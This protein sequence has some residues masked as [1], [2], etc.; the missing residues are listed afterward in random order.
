MAF[1]AS[2]IPVKPESSL[3]PTTDERKAIKVLL[4]DDDPAI[5]EELNDVIEI[6]GWTPITASSVDEAMEL[7]QSDQ[8]IRVVVTDVHFGSGPDCANGIQFVSRA[9]AKFPNRA[10]SYLVLSGDSDQFFAS[11]DESAF[12]FLPKPPDPQRLI[13][14]IDRAVSFDDGVPNYHKPT[15]V[16]GRHV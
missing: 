1:F 8:G 7:L 11:K 4:V 5:L 12:K 2:K 14:T 15:T 9:R 16:S 3:E 10:L 6:E 13:D